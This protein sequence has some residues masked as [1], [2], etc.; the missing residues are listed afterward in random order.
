MPRIVNFIDASFFR[1]RTDIGVNYNVTAISNAVANAQEFELIDVIGRN[2]Y[3]SLQDHV[4]AFRGA[5]ATPIPV[6]YKTLLDDYIANFVL[7][8]SY[9]NLLESIYLKPTSVGIGSRVFPG[10]TAISSSQ[11]ESKRDSVRPKVDHF[12]L[13]LRQYIEDEGSQVFSELGDSEDL[14][15]DRRKELTS[16]SS[17]LLTFRGRKYGPNIY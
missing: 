6:A 12:S 5:D 11:Y 9:Y 1:S 2:L 14:P 10:G 4:V 3:D 8:T 17:P 7:W 13:R 16:T 15:A